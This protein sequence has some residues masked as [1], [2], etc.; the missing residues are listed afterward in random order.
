MT[1]Q[2]ALTEL[3]ERVGA[4][5]GAAVFVSAVE[6]D[7]WPADAVTAMKAQ[8][9]LVK[10]GPAQSAVCPGCEQECVMPVHVAPAQSVAAKAFIVC[11]KRSDI[12][13]VSVPIHALEQLQ[14]SG[15]TIANML[16]ELLELRSAGSVD[17]DATRWEIG[18]YKGVKHASH[19][20]LLGDDGFRLSLA[21]HLL[22]LDDVLTYK[23]KR[24]TADRR[25]LTR[26]VDNPVAGAGDA[27]SAEQRRNRIRAR[28]D[29]EKAKGT[30]AFLK[31]V[32][33]EEGISRSRVKALVKNRRSPND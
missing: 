26:C 2:D 12:N 23:S 14:A 15:E 4:R 17:P 16:T 13:R 22:A 27:E 30:K 7:R 1:G 25:L 31:V 20:V 10:A 3:L 21:G 18:M 28:V 5:E 19:L 33:E 32:A 29:E 9:L 6:I 24:I 8:Q 11:D